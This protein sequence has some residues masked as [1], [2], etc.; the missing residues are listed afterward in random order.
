MSIAVVVGTRPEIIKMAPVVKELE[1]RD[2][3]FALIHT[4]QHYDY[5]MSKVFIDELE[6]P[7][8]HDS[9]IL[10]NKNPAAK[11]GE[12]MIKLGKSLRDLGKFRIM[13]IQGDTDTM[14]AAGLTAA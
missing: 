11:I 13:L 14:L 8:P 9:F 4:G 10:E 7:K 2:L 5:Q 12:M 6:L 1:R 3:H